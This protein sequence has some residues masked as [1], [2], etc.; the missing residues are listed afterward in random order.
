MAASSLS[1]ELEVAC[2]TPLSDDVGMPMSVAAGL[3]IS[4]ATG[5]S[6]QPFPVPLCCLT[7]SDG[8]SKERRLGRRSNTNIAETWSRRATFKID[9]AAGVL[10]VVQ[11]GN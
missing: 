7:N 1:A 2:G 10:V 6:M 11:E 3:V 8:F 4:R 9:G 5:R